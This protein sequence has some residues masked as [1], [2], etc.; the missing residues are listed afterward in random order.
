MDPT[1][2]ARLLNPILAN[3][4]ALKFGAKGTGNDHTA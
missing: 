4:P 3:V 1:S 2:F